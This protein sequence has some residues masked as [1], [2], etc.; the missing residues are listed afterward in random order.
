MNIPQA[1]NSSKYSHD[2]RVIPMF[3]GV[4]ISKL[5]TFGKLKVY[6][7]PGNKKAVIGNH[8]S[9]Y[10]GGDNQDFKFQYAEISATR[11]L[12]DKIWSHM[13]PIDYDTIYFKCIVFADNKV[14]IYSEYNR[15]IGSRLIGWFD[16][17]EVKQYFNLD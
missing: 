2:N 5:F 4:Q 3:D 11:F 10:G 16:W 12:A 15:I 8:I 13:I 9:F 6:P 1:E 14:S 17:D 7:H